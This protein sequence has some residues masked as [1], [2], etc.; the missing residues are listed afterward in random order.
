MQL[1][2][3]METKFN[4]KKRRNH[5]VWVVRK[6]RNGALLSLKKS[7]QVEWWSKAYLK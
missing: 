5:I 4:W 1:R 6:L 7:L 3:K 2:Q